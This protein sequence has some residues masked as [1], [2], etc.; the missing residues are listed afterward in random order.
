MSDF[1][2]LIDGNLVKGDLSMP[3]LNPAT[4]DVLAQCP[5]AP[6]AQLNA[7]VAQKILR[8]RIGTDG[9]QTRPAAP[10]LFFCSRAGFLR[11][12]ERPV[13]QQRHR[14]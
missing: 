13:Q 11:R 10:D 1:H 7:A 14:Q 9:R 12:R 6:E 8:Q 2:L 4:E 5:R 3:I